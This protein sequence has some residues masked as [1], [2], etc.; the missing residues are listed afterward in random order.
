MI[1]LPVKFYQI[2]TG[3]IAFLGEGRI[4]VSGKQDDVINFINT[5]TAVSHNVMVIY[6][7]GYIN[8]IFY[9]ANS[10]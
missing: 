7:L 6:F 4:R 10:E 2:F 8:Q 5:Y 9:S 3:L 1:N